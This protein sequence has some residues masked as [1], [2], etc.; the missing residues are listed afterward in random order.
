[1]AYRALLR[2]SIILSVAG[3]LLFSCSEIIMEEDISD[4]EITLVAPGDNTQFNSTGIT[5]SWNAVN[6]ASGYQL[7]I[8]KPNF[9]DPLQIVL[10]TTVTNTSF[11]QQ[12]V[13]GHYQWR[14]RA[15]NSAYHTNYATRSFEIVSNDN[16]Q[17]NAVALSSPSNN[18]VTNASNQNLTWQPILGSMNYQVQVYD[19]SN[20]ILLDQTTANT[21]YAFTFPEGSFNWKVRAS[22]GAE[23]TLYSSRAIMVDLTPPATPVLVKPENADPSQEPEVSF[24]WNSAFSGGSAEKDSIYIYTNA[25]Q[26][27]LQ[28]KTQ[29]ASP[30]VLTLPSGTYYWKVKSFDAAGNVSNSSSAFS[31]TVN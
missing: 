4:S 9:T 2:K 28:S 21:N 15:V 8:A 19:N 25:A 11:T 18:L 7:E 1:M 29:S 31:F 16:F 22:N 10:D 5:F 17:D 3:I 6:K 12:L 24:E 23:N 20:T 14:V 13:I 27:L 26:T 30:Y